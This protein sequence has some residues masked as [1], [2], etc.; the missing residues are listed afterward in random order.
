MPLGCPNLEYP[1][2]FDDLSCPKNNHQYKTLAF[3]T[4]VF[5]GNRNPNQIALEDFL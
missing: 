3:V 1:R 5:C 2:P 4:D